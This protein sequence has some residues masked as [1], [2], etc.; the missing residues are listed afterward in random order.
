MWCAGDTCSISL[1]WGPAEARAIPQG[2]HSRLQ[3][4]HLWVSFIPKQALV[5]AIRTEAAHMRPGLQLHI[6]DIPY[7]PLPLIPV[8]SQERMPQME[9][10]L[11]VECM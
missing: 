11:A 8:L 10:A 6:K 1:G 4:S 7:M 2:H 9:A 5:A 3:R